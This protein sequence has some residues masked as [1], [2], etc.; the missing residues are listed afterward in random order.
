MGRSTR[1]P[2]AKVVCAI[3]ILSSVIVTVLIVRLLVPEQRAPAR[4][5]LPGDCVRFVFQPQREAV[6]W[7]AGAAALV[8]SCAALWLILR[9]TGGHKSQEARPPHVVF[10]VLGYGLYAVLAFVFLQLI[11]LGPLFRFRVLVLTPERVSMSSLY[12]T[13]SIPVSDIRGGRIE[14]VDTARRGGACT[15]LCYE[16]RDASGRTHTSVRITCPR[17][18]QELLRYS[19]FLESMDAELGKRIGK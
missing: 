12:C 18:S 13:W 15:D 19:G 8:L 7:P 11:L 5:E 2:L 6:S 10:R 16:L 4:I 1:K 14:R 17:P 3:V 9:R